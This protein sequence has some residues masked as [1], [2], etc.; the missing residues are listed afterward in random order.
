MLEFRSIETGD[1]AVIHGWPPYPPEFAELNYALRDDGWLDKFRQK[2]A[3]AI[4]VARQHGEIVAFSLLSKT[5]ES[6]AEFRIALRADRLGRGLGKTVAALTL[7]Q[8][9]SDPG[10]NCIH[11]IV[12]KNNIRAQHLY[13]QLGFRE[14]GRAL[15]EINGSLID[16]IEMKISKSEGNKGDDTLFK[17]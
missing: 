7:A 4:Y 13:R 1:A 14:T 3:T 10:L 11:L 5:A 17:E 15:M 12:R 2:P 16:F 6:S 8:G 9:F